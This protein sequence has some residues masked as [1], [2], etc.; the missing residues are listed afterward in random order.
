[1]RSALALLREPAYR[2]F[3][4]ARHLC[5]VTTVRPDGSL[6]VTA[7]GIALDPDAEQAW[8][9]TFR[10]SVKVHNLTAG[11]G[12]HRIAV[13]QIAG[14]HWASL[15]GWGSIETDPEVVR[16][17]ERRYASRYRQPSVNPRRVA[18][19]IQLTRALGRAPDLP[20]SE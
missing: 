11:P 16:E 7:M 14:P 17:A 1:M 20:G 18:L 15:E 10:E 9:I 5:T 19:R 3:W 6:H 2:A 12:P 8:G 4:T 13:G